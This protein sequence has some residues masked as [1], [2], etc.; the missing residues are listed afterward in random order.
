MEYLTENLETKNIQSS[1]AYE[2]FLGKE[3]DDMRMTWAEIKKEYPDM[4]VALTYVYPYVYSMES[5]V[6]F[7]C[8][9]DCYDYERFQ[10][11]L[12]RRTR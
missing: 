8:V 3:N 9:R 5:A 1:K 12:S 10:K 4:Y 6:V 7:V 11:E 2:V